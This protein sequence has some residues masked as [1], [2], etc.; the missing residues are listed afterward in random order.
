MIRPVSL[1]ALLSLT[2][3]GAP[4]AQAQNWIDHRPN[5]GGYRVAF[6]A[7]PIEDGRNVDT[8]VGAVKMRTTAVEI[9]GRIFMTIDSIY[10]SNYAMGD[11]ESALDI[12]RDGGVSNVNGKLL[13]EEK[14]SIDSA[15]ARRVLID[16]PHTK[17]AAVALMVLDGHRLYQTVYVGPRDT[18]GTD[19]ANRFL[20]SFSLE[21]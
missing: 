16:I 1:A 20:S 12:V 9:D 5:G 10:P 7:Q 17:Q 21:R 2:L 4:A 8:S 6:P 13:S 18:Q 19:E 15:P 11:P 3:I 14:L